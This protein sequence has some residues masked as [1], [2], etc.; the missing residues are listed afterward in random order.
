MEVLTR[1]L[2]C[3]LMDS[4]CC[5]LDYWAGMLPIKPAPC[6]WSIPLETS[7]RTANP[8]PFHRYFSLHRP[9]FTLELPLKTWTYCDTILSVN[10]TKL[11]FHFWTFMQQVSEDIFMLVHYTDCCQWKQICKSKHVYDVTAQLDHNTC[12]H[13]L[14]TDTIRPETHKEMEELCHVTTCRT[15]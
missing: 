13:P 7:R 15:L 5:A 14:L 6:C 4:N 1:S 12:T 2:F 11:H 9:S 3:L 8:R 10:N